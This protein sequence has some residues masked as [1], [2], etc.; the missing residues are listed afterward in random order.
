MS[1]KTGIGKAIGIGIA[2]VI[3]L[4]AISLVFGISVVAGDL[5]IM[6]NDFLSLESI[7][8]SILKLIVLGLV[9]WGVAAFWGMLVSEKLT[10]SNIPWLIAIAVITYFLYPF[11]ASIMGADSLTAITFA[12]V[13]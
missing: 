11:A 1:F 12:L 5:T 7:G 10:K 4:H 6:F 13:P 2:A 8:L 3:L 9:I